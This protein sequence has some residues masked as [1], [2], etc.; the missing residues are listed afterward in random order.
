M[1][2]TF[3][4]H[5]TFGAHVRRIFFPSHVKPAKIL[6]M[7]H[8]CRSLTH[9]ILPRD[10]QFS[11]TGLQ[12]II[13]T[14]KHLLQLDVYARGDFIDHTGLL[15]VTAASVQELNVRSNFVHPADIV[16]S[17]KEWAV[18]GNP[19]PSV[20]NILIQDNVTIPYSMFSMWLES[21]LPSFEIGMYDIKQVPMNLHPQ[22]PLRKFKFGPVVSPTLIRL[23]NHGIVGLRDD[24]FC[25]C[26]YTHHDTVKYAI[27]PAFSFKWWLSTTI[28]N[29]E[30]Y[31]SCISHLDSVT[32]VDISHENVHSVHLEQ[33]A[34]MCP[35]LQ[36]LNLKENVN[37][38]KDLKG[39]DAIVHICHNLEGINLTGISVLW[40]ESHLLL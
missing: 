14:K 25:L 2:A 37:C 9:I 29:E 16:T 18:Q 10:T 20:I 5:A 40:V 8:Q 12:E 34:I 1:Y 21:K 35:N 28:L 38:L 7:V 13:C 15:M 26:E 4:C 27:S 36:R 30:M 33:L 6:E 19:L 23:S 32:Y 3:T 17:I 31:F 39:L 24:I 11:L 22:V